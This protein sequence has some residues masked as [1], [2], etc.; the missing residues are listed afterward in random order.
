[1]ETKKRFINLFSR[2]L[3]DNQLFRQVNPQMDIEV[4]MQV[5]EQI[6]QPVYNQ[7]WR[8]VF[9]PVQDQLREKYKCK[10]EFL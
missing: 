8:N 4:Y 6:R 2:V 7:V 10:Y 5:F 3:V 1:M 9:I